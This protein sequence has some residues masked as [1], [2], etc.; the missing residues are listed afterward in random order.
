MELLEENGRTPGVK[1]RVRR[2]KKTPIESNEPKRPR[3]RPR[4]YPIV[5]NPENNAPRIKTRGR[6]KKPANAEPIVRKSLYFSCVEKSLI[7]AASNTV[8]L[9]MGG[10]IAESANIVATNVATG[11]NG[12]ERLER[13]DRRGEIIV[14]SDVKSHVDFVTKVTKKIGVTLSEFY[15]DTALNRAAEIKARATELDS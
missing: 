10:F 9:S 1:Q 2:E 11:K 6:P 5:K 8:G 7:R 4:K 15:A 13:T 12:F 3:G 14:A